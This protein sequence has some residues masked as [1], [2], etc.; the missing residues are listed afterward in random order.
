[1]TACGGNLIGGEI[2]RNEQSPLCGVATIELA[3]TQYPGAG[4]G[5]DARSVTLAPTN[6]NLPFM[7][8]LQ[9]FAPRMRITPLSLPAG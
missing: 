7:R 2:K 9:A 4:L 1:M 8:K 3:D 5:A 6:P